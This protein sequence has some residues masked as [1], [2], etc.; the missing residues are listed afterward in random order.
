MGEISQ[1][2]VT[3]VP[4]CYDEWNSGN[5]QPTNYHIQQQQQKSDWQPINS[6][7]IK[8]DYSWANGWLFSFPWDTNRKIEQ[9]ALQ[10]IGHSCLI[11]DGFDYSVWQVITFHLSA[12]I[13]DFIW[14]TRKLPKSIASEK[15]VSFCQRRKR[16]KKQT[17]LQMTRVTK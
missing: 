10:S 9:D 4:Q 7:T 8:S 13:Y 16:V 11:G 2:T 1:N 14:S 17:F 12:A 6:K 5:L 15:E 3:T